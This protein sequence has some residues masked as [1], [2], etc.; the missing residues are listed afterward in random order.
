MNVSLTTLAKFLLANPEHLQ[1]IRARIQHIPILVQQFDRLS[2]QSDVQEWSRW[3]EVAGQEIPS[4][5]SSL[6]DELQSLGEETSLSLDRAPEPTNIGPLSTPVVSVLPLPPPLSAIA[7]PLPKPPTPLPP[8][9]PPHREDASYTFPKPPPPLSPLSPHTPMAK[10][11]SPPTLSWISPPSSPNLEAALFGND[12]VGE[13]TMMEGETSPP[14][15]TY[16]QTDLKPI[17][18]PSNLSPPALQRNQSAG[19]LPQPVLPPG[20]SRV[21]QSPPPP[22]ILMT[23]VSSE[24][25]PAELLAGWN[26]AN[27]PVSPST[28]SPSAETLSPLKQNSQK[29]PSPPSKQKQPEDKSN[30]AD[31]SAESTATEHPSPT[32]SVPSLESKE[33]LAKTT[34]MSVSES[35]ND[36]EQPSVEATTEKVPLVQLS[37]DA[38]KQ[39]ARENSKQVYSG[40]LGWHRY[41]FHLKQG[42]V[43]PEIPAIPETNWLHCRIE[44]DQDGLTIRELHL[45]FS[46]KQVLVYQNL[47]WFWQYPPNKQLF[48]TDI[49]NI[50]K[51]LPAELMDFLL[52]LVS[53]GLFVQ[54]ADAHLSHS[55]SQ[56]IAPQPR[57][58]TS[59][60]SRMSEPSKDTH[61][62][63]GLP[64]SA[65]S[66]PSAPLSEENEVLGRSPFAVRPVSA[67][68]GETTLTRQAVL[69]PLQT[70]PQP[71][72]VTVLQEIQP[73]WLQR[74]LDKWFPHP[75]Q[76]DTVSVLRVGETQELTELGLSI[77]FLIESTSFSTFPW[78]RITRDPDLHRDATVTLLW[79]QE[80]KQ[81]LPPNCK[82]TGAL[83]RSTERGILQIQFEQHGY[84]PLRLHIRWS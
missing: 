12:D 27:T 69:E 57:S 41:Q 65:L 5:L 21:P 54:A 6:L 53:P 13:S 32:E 23:T 3:L 4:L 48:R 76:F 55:F 24:S 62:A 7:T 52:D 2:L 16:S 45:H 8:L 26:H 9:L 15:L 47:L 59:P 40:G 74:W 58:T 10:P 43:L 19:S 83:S 84:Q 51:T 44:Q 68:L 30:S 18:S 33:L 75:P 77:T 1:K 71:T 80:Q 36:S 72:Y 17:S 73:T 11:S 37:S 81:L 78:I 70:P 66:D 79:N 42:R 31:S 22:N 67:D 46:E 35:S 82:S 39:I 25:S 29:L 61:R 34:A 38:K 49:E 63:K 28:E 14:V 20:A 60:D 50:T 56:A 64:S